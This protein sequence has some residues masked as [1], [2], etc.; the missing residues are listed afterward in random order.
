MKLIALIIALVLERLATQLF[1][2]R[3][4]RWLDYLIDPLLNTMARTLRMHSWLAAVTCLVVLV[5]P[6]VLMRFGIGDALLG[7]PY[8]VLSVIVLFFSLGPEDI[9]EEVEAWCRAVESGD[10]EL[11]R[12]HAKAILECDPRPNSRLADAI[13]IQGNNR[14]FSVVFWFVVLGPI[15]AAA[16]RIADLIRRRALFQAARALHEA[17]EATLDSAADD[18]ADTSVAAASDA[19]HSLLVWVPARITALSYALAGSFDSGREAWS[20]GASE[21]LGVR[22]D[23]LLASVGSAALSFTA[24]EEETDNESRVREA[25]QSIRLVYRALIF[26]AVTVAALTL[27]GPA[28]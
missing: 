16:V 9:G 15:G 28:V 22:N 21:E 10:D 7:V 27:F 26:W 2:L 17:E 4:L 25:R 5:M 13:F 6:V 24:R 1:H 20:V 3:T 19:I 12:H 23:H 11:R 8:V 18:T 14:I